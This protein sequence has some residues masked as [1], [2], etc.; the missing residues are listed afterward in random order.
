VHDD[1]ADRARAQVHERRD[2][3]TRMVRV[4]ERALVVAEDLAQREA[5]LGR[6]AAARQRGGKSRQVGQA[7][8]D[9]L[10]RVHRA[11]QRSARR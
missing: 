10:A 3:G 11:R 1:G 7:R 9:G 4:G 6:H 2:V 5:R 8:V